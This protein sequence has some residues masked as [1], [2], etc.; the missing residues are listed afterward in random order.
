MG[1]GNIKPHSLSHPHVVNNAHPITWTPHAKFE[2]NWSI[3]EF[4][5]GIVTSYGCGND[6]TTPIDTHK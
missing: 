1:V 2:P 6:K 4:L 5:L 3:N